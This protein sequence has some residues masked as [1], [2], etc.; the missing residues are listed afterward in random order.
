MN[1]KKSL[2]TVA[3]CSVLALALSVPSFAEKR[4]M[5]NLTRGLT[6][7]NVGSGV[8]VSWR[9]L[10][11]DAPDV[12]FNLYR[13]GTKIASI[14]KTAG[15]N[16][17]DKD[18][19]ATSKYAVSAVSGGKEGEKSAAEIVFTDAK[20]E[21]NVN[22]PY[23]VLKLDVPASQKMPDGSTCT[24]T[25]NDMSVGD[26]DGDGQ[27]D[28]VLKWDPSNAQDNSK[29]GYT[30]SV[31]VDGMKL[32]GTRLWRIDLGKN[33]RAGAH[34]TQF[35]VYDLDGDGIAEIVMKTSDGTV[36]G[37][38]K[39]I[40]DASKDYRT[41]A[42][43]IMSG[44]EFLTVF[45]GNTGEEVTT[46][47][48][49]PKRNITNSW[50]DT[51]GNRSERML[52]AVA[53]LDG[54][55]PSVIMNRGY[56]T[57]AYLVAYDFDGKNLK[58]RWKHTSDKSGQGLYGEGNHNLSVGDLDGDGKD[59]I[60]FGAAALNSD[61]TLRYR[62]GF[63]HGDAMHLSDMDPD[64]PGLELYD[65]H[66]DKQNKYSEEYRD[67]DG[68][69]LWG[70]TQTEAGN[71]DNGRGMA[72]DIDS[73]NRGFEM[74]SGTS[75]G[76][77][78]VKGQVVTTTGL[79]QNFR[80]Y[81]DG[82][83]QDELMDGTGSPTVENGGATGGKIEKYNSSK[84]TLD[85]LFSFYN[86]EGASLNNWTKANPC[87]VADLFG[88]WREE[89]IVRSASDPSKVIVFTTP[90][91]SPYRVYT[92][93]H[94]SH[95][96]VSIA[97]QNVAYN[98]PPHL[99][100]YLPDAVKSLKQPDMYVVGEVPAPAPDTTSNP[101]PTPTDSTPVVSDG[102]SELDASTP[103][104]GDGVTEKSN[105]GFLKNGY[106]NFTN[107]ASSYGTWEIF[108]PT[109]AKTTLTIR[110]TNG[111]KDAR[112]MSLSVNG[113]ASETV[114]FPST[115]ESWTTYS[116]A[117]VDVSLVAGVNTLKFTSVTSDG[118]P[119][120]DMFTFGIDGVEIY[121][122]SQQIPDATTPMPVVSLRGGVS[123]NPRTGVLYT[124][125][126]GFAEVYFYDMS[127]AMRMGVSGSVKAGANTIELDRNML[128]RGMFVVK[129]RIDGKN[130]AVSKFWNEVR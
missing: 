86:V 109:A 69:V 44:N 29:D 106:Y 111:G 38:G 12:E 118:G 88:D 33:I 70:T 7:A 34:Y 18:G 104:E 10:G 63:G 3:A 66:E 16:Y 32:D 57:M 116:E 98:Q 36:D 127:G 35:M 117:K 82:D 54:V 67:K 49:W 84:K 42:G 56:Y 79:S 113:G 61:G 37:K 121:D 21:G 110:Y 60:V 95:Y 108:S 78:S 73:T 130:A 51:Y 68:K 92:L 4:Q 52:A 25:P 65:V 81:F 40:G 112:S 129:V 23:K 59:E 80:I 85:R 31:F 64:N 27:L 91:T 97:W 83:L 15:T 76:A 26:L 45:K 47:D 50:G 5:E 58:E 99:G 46:I 77:R 30:G 14:G 1:R 120:F 17:L 24:Y 62:T 96:R 94:D 9:L 89:F 2:G 93:M 28:L 39:V 101:T 55:H 20:K 128:P 90:F 105:E 100:Y 74:W 124:P 123:F 87:I 122:G 48:Y 115:S 102:K 103:K 119:N 41:S 8:L 107:S 126:A 114:N 75:K 125:R 72:A 71:V 13:D 53:Y 22:F 6:V 19:K 43:R 11:T